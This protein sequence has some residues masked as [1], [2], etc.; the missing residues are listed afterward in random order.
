M[1]ASQLNCR[2]PANEQTNLQYYVTALII[3]HAYQATYAS[4]CKLDSRLI[5]FWAD[6]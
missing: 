4:G 6:S 3:Y 1:T 5:F 2:Q